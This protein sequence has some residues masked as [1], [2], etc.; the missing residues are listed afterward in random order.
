MVVRLFDNYIYL[1]YRSGLY[2]KLP[3]TIVFLDNPTDPTIIRRSMIIRVHGLVA[4]G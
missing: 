1:L 2:I 4:G 3:E